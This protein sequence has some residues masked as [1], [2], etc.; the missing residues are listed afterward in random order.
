[1]SADFHR[2]GL[3]TWQNSDPDQCAESVRTALEVGYRHIDT[4]Q[5]YENEE[6]VGNGH[7]QAD[8]ARED[9][10]VATKVSTGNLAY[11]DVR[12]STEQ[13]L[14]RLGLSYV[15]LLYVHW[16]IRTYDPAETL[17]AF[18]DLYDDGLIKNVGV[19]NFEP[20]QLETAV[21]RL[22]A[23]IFA[24]QVEMHPLCPQETLLEFAREDD[25]WVVAYSPLAKGEILS[26]PVIED[27][28]E[29]IDGTPAQVCLAWLLGKDSVAAIP[30]A[31][32][33]AHIRENFG[34]TDVTLSNEQIERIDAIDEQERQ[35]DPDIAPWNQSSV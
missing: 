10:F 22:S 6:A 31:T 16:P 26:H 20:G 11:D 34:A 9:V 17:V 12:A 27:V 5:L 4:A 24:H 23:P 1:M 15:D 32:G 33:E 28:A 14:D 25:H 35:V 21:D 29:E 13:S 8:V 19:S 3:G 30:K 18:D 2:L 7:E